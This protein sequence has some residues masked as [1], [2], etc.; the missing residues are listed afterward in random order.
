MSNEVAIFAAL[1]AGD[2]AAAL[3]AGL[4]AYGGE[5]LSFLGAV[6]GSREEAAEVFARACADL[7]RAMSAFRRGSSFRT[8]MYAVARNASRHHR[9][10]EKRHR[11][12]ALSDAP[13]I[14]AL[15]HTTTEAFFK[16]DWKDKFRALRDSLEPDD[17]ALL[18]L[19]V[20][21]QMAWDEIAEVLDGEPSAKRAAAL[22]K[23]FER[24]KRTLRE[25]A[26][27][28]GLWTVEP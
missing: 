12:G 6:H 2:R 14:A 15:V 19:R 27:E 25:R 20:D 18:V 16:T 23:R 7:V 22:R 9:E 4:E 24:I 21:R 3:R 5:L 1:D 17:R 10:D 28:A 13:E 26:I 8:W 11:H